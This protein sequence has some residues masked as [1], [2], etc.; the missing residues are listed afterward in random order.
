MAEVEGK[1]G[2]KNLSIAA[3][4]LAACLSSPCECLGIIIFFLPPV[5]PHLRLVY[6]IVQVVPGT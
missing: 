1:A 3:V 2:E 4:R 5:D 6:D